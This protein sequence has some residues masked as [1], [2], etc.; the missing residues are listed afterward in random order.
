M[1]FL[2]RNQVVRRRSDGRFDLVLP[3]PLREVLAGL[4]GELAELLDAGPDDPALRRLNPPAYLD[5][6]DR[7]LE[8]R[9]LAGEELRS[10]RRAAVEAVE[11]SLGRDVV[12]EDELWQWLQTLNALRLVVGTR[13]DVD[14]DGERPTVDD[15][16]P[17]APLWHV[18]DL[19][20][21]L[22]HSVVDA[23]GGGG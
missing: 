16:D 8:Y 18:Y 14:D 20:T 17:E 12:D 22:Q 15:D 2:R 4:L 21:W 10:S 3:P 1:P 7:E 6:E 13:L 11:T 9:L 23:L 5:D 19:T